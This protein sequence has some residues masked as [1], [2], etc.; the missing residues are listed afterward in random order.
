MPRF[1]HGRRSIIAPGPAYAQSPHASHCDAP[2]IST[3][4]RPGVPSYEGIVEISRALCAVVVRCSN[5]LV[6]PSFGEAP[7]S[8]AA[9][10]VAVAEGEAG[11]PSPSL[12]ERQRIL[13]ASGASF[14][15]GLRD[16]GGTPAM[17]SKNAI[18]A[19]SPFSSG[20]EPA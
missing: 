7:D 16:G 8:C 14:E 6:S 9:A 19:P 17:P 13:T 5:V 1:R 10:A 2:T 4:T 12:L 15:D 20:W 3:H 18:A 11:K